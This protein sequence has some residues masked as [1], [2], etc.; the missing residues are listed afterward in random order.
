M[1]DPL[2]AQISLGHAAQ[3]AVEKRDQLI[4]GILV[5]ALPV[6]KEPRNVGVISQHNGFCGL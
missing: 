4:S 1:I 6:D 3:F 5:A 2:V